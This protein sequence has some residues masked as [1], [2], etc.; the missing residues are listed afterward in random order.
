MKTLIV[1]YSFSGN[2]KVLARYLQKKIGADLQEIV[3]LKHRTGFTI[4]LDLLFKRTPGIAPPNINWSQYDR[5]LLL[6]PIWAGRIASP[7][8]AFLQRE[9]K[10]IKSY[11]FI[12]LCGTGGNMKIA[13]ELTQLVQQAP[14]AVL[15]L[16]ANQ[17]LPP[18]RK[19]KIRYTSGLQVQTQQLPVFD[20]ALEKVV[21]VSQTA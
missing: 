15:E 21:A 13:T 8:K 3:E 17:L 5:V 16:T 19:N 4:L 14:A 20:S 18:E 7:L 6:A 12:S 9:R 2:N 1:F 10:H 11:S